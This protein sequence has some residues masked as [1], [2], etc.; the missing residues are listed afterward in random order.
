MDFASESARFSKQNIIAQAGSYAL[1]Q[2][3]TKQQ[4]VLQLLS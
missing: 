4:A 3:N 2:A 1:T